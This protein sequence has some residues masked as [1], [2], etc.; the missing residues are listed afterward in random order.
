MRTLSICL[1]T[2]CLYRAQMLHS[3]A[4]IIQSCLKQ[5]R[6]EFALSFSSPTFLMPI[7]HFLALSLFSCPSLLPFNATAGNRRSN[8][9]C[10]LAVLPWENAIGDCAPHTCDAAVLTDG[11]KSSAPGG[12]GEGFCSATVAQC[13]HTPCSWAEF[14]QRCFGSSLSVSIWTVVISRRF[15][16]RGLLL[17][18]SW[19]ELSP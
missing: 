6:A 14:K 13:Q 2:L 18:H 11:T 19:W 7:L 3:H 8:K 16:A 12:R 17:N 15:P 4:T 1:S 10:E 9:Q 5:P